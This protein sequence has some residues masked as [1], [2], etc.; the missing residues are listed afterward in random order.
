MINRGSFDYVIIGAGSAGCVLANRLSADPKLSVLLLEAGPVDRN[1]WIHVPLGYGRLFNHPVLNWGYKTRPEPHLEHREISQPRGKVL[2]G[3]S[4]INGLVYI[5]GQRED[6]DEWANAG[7]SG[8]SYADVLPY[9]KR[10]ENQARGADE[11]HGVDGPLSVS[12]QSE[13]HMLCDAYIAAAVEAGH[14]ANPDFNGAAQEGAGYFQTTS[15]RGRRCSAAVAYLRPARRRP[16]LT[17]VTNAHARRILFDGTRAIGVEWTS[18]GQLYRAYGGRET[19]LAAGAINTPQ[20]LELSGVGDGQRLQQLGVEVRHDNRAVGENLQD[21]LQVRCVF[22]TN[23]NVTLNDDMGSLVRKI[24]MAARYVLK[25][26]GPLTVSA[27][28]AGGFFRTAAAKDF[29]PDMEVHFITFST[30][31]MGDRL[32]PFS[33]FTASSCQLRPTSRGHVHAVSPDPMAPPD[34]LANYLATEEDRATNIAGLRLI[35]N[36]IAQPSIA[37][38]ITHERL[39]GAALTSDEALLEYTRQHASSLYHPTCT[40]AIGQV[41][42]PQLRVTGV[43]G[44]R[45]VDGSVMPSVVSGNCNAAIIAI[46]ERAADLILG[47]SMLE[48]E[49]ANG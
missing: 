8:W 13:P 29:R 20:L 24:R 31:K 1:P 49:M 16:N 36:I 14:P 30:N 27:G 35:R 47:R 21:H 4:S 39:P 41:V 11:W 6:F 44:L 19:I 5:R 15:H 10:A 28:Y 17:I 45:V 37:Q 26:K 42:D 40:A 23:Q 7:A 38:Y 34:I 12:D 22:E 43:S 18:A 46:A 32:D 48:K 25:R 33:A 2:G 3:S 9:F